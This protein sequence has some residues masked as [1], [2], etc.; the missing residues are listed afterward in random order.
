MDPVE[1]VEGEMLLDGGKYIRDGDRRRADGTHGV[2]LRSTGESR[3]DGR[4]QTGSGEFFSMGSGWGNRYR[5]TISGLKP[6]NL[7]IEGTRGRRY[8]AAGE[9]I[10]C[11]GNVE[12]N[13]KS[14]KA[15]E[16]GGRVVWVGLVLTYRLLFRGYTVYYSRVRYC[17][18]AG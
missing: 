15:W 18:L 8:P 3:D 2:F 5:W 16:I 11:V 6:E 17:V 10:I 4:G 13:G 7:D 9:K 12:G 1:R 14:S